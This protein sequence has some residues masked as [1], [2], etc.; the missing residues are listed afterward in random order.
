MNKNEPEHRE[1]RHLRYPDLTTT[2]SSWE[3]TGM[4]PAPPEDDEEYEAYQ[5]LYGMEF[6][7]TK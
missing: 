5:E 1:D 3:C 7:K 4:I 6:P 2:V